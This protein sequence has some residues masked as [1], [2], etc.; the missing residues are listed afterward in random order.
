MVGLVGT[1]ASEI[2]AGYL[3]WTQQKE[4]RCFTAPARFSL[5]LPG[6]MLWP[7]FAVVV[8]WRLCKDSM[9][10]SHFCMMAAQQGQASRLPGYSRHFYHR[11]QSSACPPEQLIGVMQRHVQDDPRP[12]PMM[13]PDMASAC[14][15]AAPCCPGD[16]CFPAGFHQ[17]QVW[18]NGQ[19]LIGRRESPRGEGSYQRPAVCCGSLVHL[20]PAL[21]R[22]GESLHREVRGAGGYRASW[23][24]LDHI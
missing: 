5:D 2:P 15:C 17:A 10:P 1:P 24:N 21:Q 18:A 6:A 16:T 7:C 12:W 9:P 3:L 14:S 19:L 20:G 8:T 11:A 4:E 22:A 13:S 23:R